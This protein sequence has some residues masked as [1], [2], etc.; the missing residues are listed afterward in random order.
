MGTVGNREMAEAAGSQYNTEGQGFDVPECK[1]MDERPVQQGVKRLRQWFFEIG[2][3][4][5]SAVCSKSEMLHI[6]ESF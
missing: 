6:N 3:L 2:P 1:A 4:E 5:S